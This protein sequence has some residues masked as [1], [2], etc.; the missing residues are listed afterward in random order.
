MTLKAGVRTPAFTMEIAFMRTE[1]GRN[2]LRVIREAQGAAR[3][4][5]IDIAI[6]ALMRRYERDEDLNAYL[7]A[8]DLYYGRICLA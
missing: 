3:Y 2:H 1:L 4:R 7:D 5:L 6:N 8:E